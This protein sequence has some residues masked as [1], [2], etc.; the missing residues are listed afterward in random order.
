MQNKGKFQKGFT[1]I[2]MILTTTLM[3]T[4]ITLVI[5]DYAG[6]TPTRNLNVTH[7]GM[8]SDI[9]KMQSFA[10]DSRNIPN[11]KAASSYGVSIDLGSTHQYVLSGWDN[12]ATPVKYTLSTQHLPANITLTAIS[13]THAGGTAVTAT[14]ITVS[15]SVPFAR[16]LVTTTGGT[17]GTRTNEADD[18]VT[19]TYTA[20]GFSAPT[21]TILMNS[22]T[23]NVQ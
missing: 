7:N 19:V 20:P 16:M 12:S 21:G 5:V 8:V 3:V 13:L 2:E 11:G 18:V 23:G 6:L 1:L 17:A 4:L 22:V 10:V 15:Y 9:R 14:T